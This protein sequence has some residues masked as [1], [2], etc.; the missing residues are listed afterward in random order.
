MIFKSRHL[1]ALSSL[2][3]LAACNKQTSDAT[4]ADA[5]ASAA[6][7]AEAP[8]APAEAAAA[9]TAASAATPDVPLVAGDV[10]EGKDY[11]VIPNGAPLAPLDGKIEVAEVF[12][13][14]CPHCNE[15]EPLVEAWQAKQPADVRY[16]PVPAAG[17]Q[18]DPLA[19]IYYAAQATNQL[20][21][22]HP[23][24]FRGIHADKAF[25]PAAPREE[26]FAYLAKHGVDTKAMASAADSFAMGARL[27]QAVQ[28]AQRSG[29]TGFP[30]LI[31]DG[32]YRITGASMDDTL[33]I[34]NGLIAKERAA[35]QAASAPAAAPAAAPAKP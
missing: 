18:N 29:V 1:L 34:A 33:R 3:M 35:M 5:A 4:P 8:A 31:V 6:T 2:L 9:N 22:V 7:S 17:G 19:R 15:F 28:F 20:D 27:G 14:W 11:E 13:Y 26:M 21:K 32:K 23:A 25:A 12:A 10:V 16:T 30:T 24:M